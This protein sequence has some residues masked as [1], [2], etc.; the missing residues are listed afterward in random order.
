MINSIKYLCALALPVL[1][2][3][4]STGS[5]VV[6]GQQMPELE[7]EKVTVFEEAPAFDYKVIGT[8]RASSDGGFT[9]ESRKEKATEELKAQA[10]KVGANGVILDGVSQLS[11]RR[12]GTGVGIS[13]NSSGGLGTSIGSSFSFPTAEVK[14]T[15]IYYDT[16]LTK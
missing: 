15:A 3:G 1:L 9:E 14:G 8:V 4:C 2:L 11:F 13:A 7:V 12:L 16:G 10:A 6:T 5:H